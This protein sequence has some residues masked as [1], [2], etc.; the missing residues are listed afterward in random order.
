VELRED[1]GSRSAQL[2]VLDCGPGVAEESLA[3]IFEPFERP[4]N[5]AGIQASGHGLGLTIA[6]RIVEAHGGRIGAS[7]RPEGGLSVRLALPL[8]TQAIVGLP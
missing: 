2:L 5:A 1:A 3:K 8:A 7:N 4:A 6:R